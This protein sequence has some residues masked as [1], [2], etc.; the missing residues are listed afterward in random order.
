MSW[1][2][3]TINSKHDTFQKLSFDKSD[4]FFNYENN[5]L[6]LH[7]GGNK[8][9][10]RYSS[11]CQSNFLVSG[12][13]IH[14]D[15]NSS[16]LLTN[17]EWQSIKVDE[18]DS[19][20]GHYV[21]IKWID[22][23]LYIKTDVLGLRDIYIAKFED[24]I[25]FSTR[26]DQITK[27]VPTEI[28]FSEFAGRWRLFSQITNDSIFKNIDR[29][30]CG[31]SVEICLNTLDIKINKDWFMPTF[32]NEEY[33]PDKFN[34]EL[35]NLIIPKTEKNLA[36]NLSGGFDSR[37][38]LS[39]Y[40]NSNTKF[41][42]QT[43]GS[44][45]TSD[46]I[47]ANKLSEKLNLQHSH[48]NLP[49]ENIDNFINKLREYSLQTLVNNPASGF[50]LINNLSAFQNKNQLIID[51]GFGEIWRR[52]FYGRLYLLGKDAIIKKDYPTI[53]KNISGY[54]ADFF[55]EEITQLMEKS[56]I[57]QIINSFDQMPDPKH[58]GLENFLD[59]WTLRTRLCNHFSQEQTW[60]DLQVCNYMP[61]A[62][63]SMM[64]NLFNLNI[65]HKNN[66]QLLKQI[67]KR[68]APILTKFPLAKGD[69]LL[70]F[71]T[72]SVQAKIIKSVLNLLGKKGY[73]DDTK[74][75]LIPKLKT[76]ILDQL[77]S[78]SV[79]Q[80]SIYDKNKISK[81]SDDLQ[82]NNQNSY[83]EIDWWLSFH[84]FYEGIG[85]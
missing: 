43:Y 1:I 56:C 66:K 33:S 65:K 31:T 11:N 54:H 17:E 82:N 2:W 20:D 84:L 74:L 16:H 15:T 10:L 24:T 77:N 38:V 22:D 79:K 52:D 41:N 23:K 29:I 46:A 80:N 19:I 32:N 61:F 81:M 12:I 70:P 34:C 50:V 78:N 39:Y 76:Y 5:N 30:C 28:D 83:N 67:I 37:V 47:L 72:N 57:N 62:Q 36:I 3:G 59:L 21:Y 58:I 48:I 13:G 55:I 35:N 8:D 18:F 44:E 68:N 26:A 69:Y 85:K 40:L 42:T 9:T 75:T 4:C 45:K 60:A 25:Y 53:V 7:A 64:K 73:K 63:P 27:F 49:I 14:S 51:G 6:R 71:N